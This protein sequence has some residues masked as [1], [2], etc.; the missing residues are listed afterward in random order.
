MQPRPP[1]QQEIERWLCRVIGEVIDMDP[2][3]VDRSTPFARFG[4]D[5]ATALI[6]TDMLNEWLG[7]DLD[8]TLLYDHDHVAALASYLARE[9]EEPV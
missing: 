3:E 2:D 7:R 5:S 9:P 1:T 6:I 4:I 8:A